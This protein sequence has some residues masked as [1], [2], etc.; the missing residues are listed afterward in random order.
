M[1]TKSVRNYLRLVAAGFLQQA[2]ADGVKAACEAGAS[3]ELDESKG[4]AAGNAAALTG[5]CR[6]ALQGVLAPPVPVPAAVR[7]LLGAVQ[8]LVAQRF[9]AAVAH[10][11]VGSL[12][13]LRFACP[14]LAA[15]DAF[16][17][18]PSQSSSCSPHSPR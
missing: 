15:P 10:K 16:G 18:L 5:A 13:F 1:A 2:L 3:V 8:L 12:M 14:A 6:R 17:L 7:G 11:A 4:G 9:D